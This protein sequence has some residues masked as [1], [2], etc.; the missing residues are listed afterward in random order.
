MIILET[1]VLLLLL[2]AFPIVAAFAGYIIGRKSKQVRD[3]FAIAVTAV[4]LGMAI[5]LC[6]TSGDFYWQGFVGYGLH[7]RADGFRIIMA[8]LA[9]FIWLMTTIQS[10]DYFATSRNRNRYY[11]FMLLTLGATMGIFL[12]AN[13]YTTFIFFEV[14]SFTSYILVIHDETPQSEDAGRSYVGFAVLGGLVTLFGLFMLHNML[15]T[16]EISEL[17]EA[18]SVYLEGGSFGTLLVA[19]LLVLFGFGVKAGMYP[20]HTW[21]PQSYLYAPAPATTLLSAILSKAGI[22]GMLVIS[23]NVFLHNYIWGMIMLCLGVLTMLTGAMLA[24]FSV[25]IKRT[26]ACSSMSQIGFIIVGIGMQGILGEHNAIAVQGTLLHLMNHSLIKL[27][28]FMGIGVIFLHVK[29]LNFNTVRGFGRKKPILMGAFGMAILGVIGMPLWNG[30]ISKTLIHES[31]VEYIAMF[32]S[33]TGMAVF[34]K[35][36]EALFTFAGGLTC[37]YMLK[38]FIA[39]FVEKNQ[40]AEE[41]ARMDAK[42]R[43]MSLPVT[44]CLIFGAAILPVLGFLPHFTMDLIV[45]AGEGFM[46][47]HGLDHAVAY[48]SWANLKGAVASLSIGVIVY[49]LIV[50]MCLMKRDVSVGKRVYI[51][52]WPKWMDIER[53]IYRPGLLRGLPFVG[54][55]AA[56]TIYSVTDVVIGGCKRILFYNRPEKFVPP[57]NNDFGTY[58]TEKKPKRISNS[59]AY[60]LLLFGVG[61][62]AALVFL[63]FA[64]LLRS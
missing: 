28:L 29:D 7:F 43:Y 1:N 48:F 36:V 16:L 62:L 21:L 17:A 49:F 12:S 55:F 11:L 44:I 40:S 33:L 2:V 37:A 45:Q 22:F 39:V 20:L 25:N 8:L 50:R 14:M 34:F 26:L 56:R 24:V 63:L 30:Y 41:Q 60:S 61:I 18:A 31:I 9:S 5:G 13:L 19:G 47:G 35:I 58:N 52:V 54:A 23:C 6:F 64:A 57:L 46:H 42:K 51:D 10:R 27:V 3:Y 38:V 15:G 32:P 53:W 59:L 4:E